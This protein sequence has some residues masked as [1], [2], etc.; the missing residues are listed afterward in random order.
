MKPP[1]KI[2]A[3]RLNNRLLRMATIGGLPSG[4]V[5]RLTLSQEDK[6][7]RNLFTEWLEELGLG[8]HVDEIGNMFGILLLILA[9]CTWLRI[10]PISDFH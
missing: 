9:F 2:N 4:G 3:D 8:V 1:L 7:A 6:A 5:K 10:Q